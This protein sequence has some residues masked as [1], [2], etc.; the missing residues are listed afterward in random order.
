MFGLRILYQEIEGR[1][2]KVGRQGQEIAENTLQVSEKRRRVERYVWSEVYIYTY[3]YSTPAL[4]ENG[5]GFKH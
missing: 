1:E 5:I 3:I 4:L 2:V